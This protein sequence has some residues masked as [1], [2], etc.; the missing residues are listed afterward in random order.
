MESIAVQI[1]SALYALIYERY[2]EQT[3]AT[4]TACLSELL[5]ANAAD[6]KRLEAGA[7]LLYPRPGAGTK[8]GKVWE[9]ADRIFKETGT[10]DREAV[11]KAC[12]LEG[13]NINTA[14]TQYSYWRKA[15][16]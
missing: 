16:P 10:A 14:S 15:N 13:I 8:T 6:Q 1:H 4:I 2:G 11:I 5:E 12:M 9:V 7:P 3:S